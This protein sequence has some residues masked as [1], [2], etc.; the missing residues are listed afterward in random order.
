MKNYFFSAWKFVPILLLAAT[1]GCISTYY[2]TFYQALKNN[3]MLM[4]STVIGAVLNIIMNLILIPCIGG[5][6]A[7]IATAISYFVIMIIRMY[8]LQRKVHKGNDEN[9]I[10]KSLFILTLYAAISTYYSNIYSF[11]I[12][13]IVLLFY[14]IKI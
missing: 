13:V 4:I 1:F 5:L 8:D 14:F 11:I 12:G 3:R 10:I 9:K 7:A 2:G 6:G